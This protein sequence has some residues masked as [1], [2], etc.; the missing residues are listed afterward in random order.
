MKERAILDQPVIAVI[1]GLIA[2]GIVVAVLLFFPRFAPKDNP[3]L[4]MAYGYAG[5]GASTVLGIA[6]IFLFYKLARSGFIWF[7]VSV[8]VG[9][10][11]GLVAY[12]LQ[13]KVKPSAPIK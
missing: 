1:T 10:L 9:Y 4:A 3:N 6:V 2:G 11:L 13:N 7:G 8:I 5:L 12:I